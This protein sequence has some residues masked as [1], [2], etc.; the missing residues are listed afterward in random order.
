[1]RWDEFADSRTFQKVRISTL[2]DKISHLLEAFEAFEAIDFGAISHECHPRSQAAKTIQDLQESAKKL[3]LESID[4]VL[5]HW[6]GIGTE[7]ELAQQN[8]ILR[9]QTW[10]ALEDL[11]RETRRET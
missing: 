10:K 4:L 3:G 11:Q 8:A 9:Q 1:V 6:P 7:I 2:S 5:P